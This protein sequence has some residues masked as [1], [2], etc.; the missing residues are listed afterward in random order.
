[1]DRV[2]LDA[3]VLFSAA[4]RSHS[5]LILLW[6]LKQV[7]LVTSEYAVEEARINLDDEAQRA[8]LRKLLE[9]VAII[10]TVS[11]GPL[12]SGVDLPE[13]DHPI[14]LTALKAKASHLLTGDKQDF[15]RYFGRRIG[16][17]L[18]LPPADYFKRRGGS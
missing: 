6:Q 14:L 3:N 8:R 5:G 13:K 18:I 7:K 15:G 16:G 1:M 17:V 9:S 2:F 10:P 11:S 4:Y 12:P